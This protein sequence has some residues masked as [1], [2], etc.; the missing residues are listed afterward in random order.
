[1]ISLLKAGAAVREQPREA[2]KLL[3][4]LLLPFGGGDFF[5]TGGEK[6]LFLLDL[7]LPAAP[8]TGVNFDIRLAYAVTAL[9]RECGVSQ[10]SF[11]VRA[12]A[13]F[14]FEEVL[15][16]SG[17]R[18]LAE[19]EGVRFLDLAAA[20]SALRDTDTG[21]LLDQAA[22][23]RPV[24]DADIIV[25]LAKF[26]SGE[27]HLFGSAMNNVRVAAALAAEYGFAEQ[28]RALVDIYSVAAPDLTIVDGLIGSSGFQPQRGDFLLAATDA[29]AADA[30][31]A[32]VAGIDLE[33]VAYLQLAA[34]Y[35]LGV[36][37]PGDIRLYGDDM[38]DVML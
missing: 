19:L 1:M 27:G 18:R 35:G 22:L 8:D 30:V 16:K 36:G 9:A 15:E 4:R 25:S 28:Q 24:L 10:L 26:R 34:Q 5:F 3:R 32:A 17:Y 7:T 11:G 2:G 37:E 14:S 33:D 38:G 21:L 29:V 23:A 12:E 31:L 20:E 6:P 13:G